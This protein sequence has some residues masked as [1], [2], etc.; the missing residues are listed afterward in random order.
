MA[1]I[2]QTE[3]PRN[4]DLNLEATWRDRAVIKL[5]RE[6]AI[7]ITIAKVIAHHA[8]IGEARQ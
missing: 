6:Y 3:S 1:R 4:D 8:G 2:A 5:A 7:P